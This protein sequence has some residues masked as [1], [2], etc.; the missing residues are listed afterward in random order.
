MSMFKTPDESK[1]EAESSDCG[2]KEEV[3]SS[4][5]GSKEEAGSSDRDSG[6][7]LVSLLPTV[8]T[9]S[10]ASVKRCLLCNRR[11]SF[12]TGFQCR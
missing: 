7:L 11:L 1:E 2:G 5:E 10:K 3:E 8:V 6:T 9:T 12:A 4:D